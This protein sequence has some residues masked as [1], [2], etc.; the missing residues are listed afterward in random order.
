LFS[1]R[2][3]ARSFDRE[4]SE[5]SRAGG[6]GGMPELM[7][8]PLTFKPTYMYIRH[9]ENGQGR[10]DATARQGMAARKS[11]PPPGVDESFFSFGRKRCPSWCDRVLMDVEGWNLAKTSPIEPTYDAVEQRQSIICDHNKVYLSFVVT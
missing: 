11:F 7:E 3:T 9:T 10:G 2:L 4:L 1:D 6:A 5:L 8:L